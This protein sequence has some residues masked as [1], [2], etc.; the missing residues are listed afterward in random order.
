MKGIKG[1][2]VQPEWAE[3]KE[4]SSGRA[5][6]GDPRRAEGD[7]P[8]ASSGSKASRTSRS[9]SK[10]RYNQSA[11]GGSLAE[12]RK[13]QLLRVFQSYTSFGERTNLRLLR[14]NKFHKMMV[15]C[16]I[17]VDKTTLDLLFVAENKHR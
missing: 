11:K 9:G 7:R 13:T 14:S 2:L 16:G 15:D 17:P 6:L 10:N 5:S 8:R 1:N 3:L 4:Q 12:E